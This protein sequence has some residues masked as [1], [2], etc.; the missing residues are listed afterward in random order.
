MMH[1]NVIV[2]GV[3]HKHEYIARFDERGWV[4]WPAK[5]GGWKE[6]KPGKESDVDPRHELEPRLGHLA[7]RLSGV[8]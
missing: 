4:T 2:Y 6:R 8:A 3:P 7:L 5:T 1:E